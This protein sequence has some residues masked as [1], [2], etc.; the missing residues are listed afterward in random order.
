MLLAYHISSR[1]SYRVDFLFSSLSVMILNALTFF[2]MWS[3]F[4][5]ITSLEGLGLYELLAIYSFSLICTAITQMSMS[6]CW[7]LSDKLKSGDFIVY[8]YKPISVLFYYFSESFDFKSLF[9]VALGTALLFFSLNKINVIIDIGIML[10]IIY[11]Q[12]FSCVIVGSITVL[13]ASSAFWTTNAHGMLALLERILDFTRFP[14]TIFNS[15]S[16]VHISYFLPISYI[17][18][19]PVMS[20]VNQDL[21]YI[22]ALSPLVAIVLFVL[23]QILWN[24]G[25]SYYEGSG[26]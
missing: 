8:Y 22:F 20:L 5:V 26:S 24:K 2:S 13:C 4:Q 15:T 21:I 19:F 16:L 23:S 25:I 6:N 12:F 3:L 9:S 11:L 18:F 17:S 14:T 1:S 10:K 7:F